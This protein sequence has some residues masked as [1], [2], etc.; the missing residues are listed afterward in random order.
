[1][2]QRRLREQRIANK[3]HGQI[4]EIEWPPGQRLTLVYKQ[5]CNDKDTSALAAVDACTGEAAH[6][7]SPIWGELSLF[8]LLIRAVGEPTSYGKEWT[9]IAEE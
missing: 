4:Q 5:S 1:M 7:E 9:S 3:S 6:H 2:P 8:K